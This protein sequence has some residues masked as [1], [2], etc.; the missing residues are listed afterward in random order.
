LVGT[1]FKHK[2][3]HILNGLGTRGV[4]LGPYLATQLFKN[5]TKNIPLEDEITIDRIYKKRNIK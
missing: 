4:M 5:I 2:N 3:L 1:H